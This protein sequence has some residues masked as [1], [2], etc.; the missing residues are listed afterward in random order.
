MKP[1]HVDILR[2]LMEE[3]RLL[4]LA[5]VVDGE[6]VI[7]MLPFA[8]EPD[9][10]ALLIHA[11]R[12]APHAAGLE[13]GAS[14]AAL[15]HGLDDPATPAGEVPRVRFQGT[16]ETLARGTPPW[17][18]GRDLYLDRFPDAG[19]TFRLGDFELFRLIVISGR[20]VA[21]FAATVNLR[22]DTLEKAAATV[23]G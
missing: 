4:S 11:S 9:W 2:V 22:R 13:A 20:L 10:G 18:A 19:V 17:I 23:H 16:V 7:G 6:P 5:V 3:R 12:L 14:F 15:V 8:A 21:G 1:E